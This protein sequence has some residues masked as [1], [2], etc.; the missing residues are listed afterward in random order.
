MYCWENILVSTNNFR[1]EFL[2]LDHCEGDEPLKRNE[3]I[4]VD[5]DQYITLGTDSVEIQAGFEKFRIPILVSRNFLIS[6]K[7][8]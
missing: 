5:E 6:L 8:V 2:I 7:I 3:S 4:E 1:V